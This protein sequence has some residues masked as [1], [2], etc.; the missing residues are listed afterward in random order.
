MCEFD[1]LSIAPVAL[2]RPAQIKRI[3]ET[4]HVSQA[5]FAP[6]LN[7]SVPAVKNERLVRSARPVPL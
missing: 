3:R 2:L 4:S 7:T 6:L 5:V 1:A